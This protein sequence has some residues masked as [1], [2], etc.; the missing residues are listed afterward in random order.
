MLQAVLGGLSASYLRGALTS[1]SALS[2]GMKQVGVAADFNNLYVKML[3]D[4]KAGIELKDLKHLEK[5][6]RDVAPELFNEFKRDAA[7]IGRPAVN[8]MRRTFRKIDSRGP[9]ADRRKK[10]TGNRFYDSMYSSYVSNISWYHTK[11]TNSR[12]S[13]DVNYKN[14]KAG[15]DFAK[16]RNGSDGTLGIVRIAIKSPAYIMADIT[17]RGNKRKGTGSLS[18]EYRIHAFGK[19][20][21]V[22][23][24]HRINANNVQGWIR[25]LDKGEAV[26]KSGKPSRY[27]YPTL[28]KHSGKFAA[29]VT[30]VLNKTITELNKKLAA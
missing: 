11:F 27:A 25:A 17:G 21:Y 5:T 4:T 28:E 12:K 30:N 3:K 14:R 23:R 6:L 29:D 18:R 7:K 8:E 1:F 13:I 26:M 24:R 15:T 19:G 22:T 2:G 16:L 9:L 10:N 20:P